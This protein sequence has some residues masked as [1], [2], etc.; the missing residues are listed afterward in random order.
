[1]TAVEH[2]EIKKENTH[3][4]NWRSSESCDAGFQICCEVLTSSYH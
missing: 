4:G 2:L 3:S 1:V